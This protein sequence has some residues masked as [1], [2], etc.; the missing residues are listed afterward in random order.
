MTLLPLQTVTLPSGTQLAYTDSWHDH[1]RSKRPREF[2]TIISLHGVAFNSVAFEPLIPHLPS[3]IRL[4]AYNQR[5][6]KESSPAFEPKEPG[7]VD[8]TAQY[9]VDLAEF[10]KFVVEE[11]GAKRMEEGGVVLLGWSKGTVPLVA[12]L[13]LLH[14]DPPSSFP[15]G[16][17][18]S[19]LPSG[20]TFHLSLLTSHLHSVLLLEPPSLALG[21]PPTSDI[22]SNLAHIFPPA[23]PTADEIISAVESWVVQY[24]DPPA[25]SAEPPTSA[26]PPSGLDCLSPEVQG[27]SYEPRT[28]LHGFTWW[29]AADNA[30]QQEVA[31][32]ALARPAVPVGLIFGGRTLESFLSAV[33]TIEGWWEEGKKEGQKE[34]EDGKEMS[35][36]AVRSIP[37][38]N[39]FAHAQEPEKFVKA[40]VE[41]I[42]ELGEGTKERFSS[43]L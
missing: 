19:A 13:S 34:E 17:F 8:A 2:T 3:S 21:L 4:I 38:T 32:K 5:D 33:K 41:L 1:P 36:T 15:S 11:K 37:L 28:I 31:K 35:R 43:H 20:I 22:I 14:H 9:V 29:T 6:Y 25:G 27:A 30:G 42:E 24:G 23:T 10:F 7:G 39:H 16:S 26:L 18:V 40:V 12:L